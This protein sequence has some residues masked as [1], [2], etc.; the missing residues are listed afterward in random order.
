MKLS[1]LTPEQKTRLLAELDGWKG[2]IQ[3]PI[4]GHRTGYKSPDDCYKNEHIPNYLTSYDAIIPLIL[5]LVESD[6][7]M[8]KFGCAAMQLKERTGLLTVIQ[9]SPSQLCG[10]VLVAAGRAEL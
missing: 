10:A 3:D 1:Q 7:G 4:D 2:I 8:M 5:K 9:L 6:D